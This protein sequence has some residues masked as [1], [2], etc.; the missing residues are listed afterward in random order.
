LKALTHLMVTLIIN[1]D[2]KSI[3][4]FFEGKFRFWTLTV[5]FATRNQNDY[6]R[7]NKQVRTDYIEL[8]CPKKRYRSVKSEKEKTKRSFNPGH[9][10][11]WYNIE[12][13]SVYEKMSEVVCD[14]K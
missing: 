13:D 5:F 11:H 14:R 10:I 7:S 8:D 12:P 4:E 2:M 1:I 3:K 9:P 6:R